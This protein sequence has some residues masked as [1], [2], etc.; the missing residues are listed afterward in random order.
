MYT[1]LI[2]YP[3]DIALE[4]GMKPATYSGSIPLH[5]PSRDTPATVL[6]TWHA[7]ACACGWKFPDENTPSWKRTARTTAIMRIAHPYVIK[8][9]IADWDFIMISRCC[10]AALP[11]AAVDNVGWYA[12]VVVPRIVVRVPVERPPSS[13]VLRADWCAADAFVV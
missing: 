11:R 8:Y 6:L 9:S 1:S 13:Q 7:P 5:C 2:P 12:I 3:L 4:E 10:V